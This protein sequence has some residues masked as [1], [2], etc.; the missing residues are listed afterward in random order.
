MFCESSS[1]STLE[2]LVIAPICKREDR[3]DRKVLI[4]GHQKP[5]NYVC[6]KILP[7]NINQ[8]HLEIS[9]L[10]YDTGDVTVNAYEQYL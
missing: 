8:W 7:Q 9:P 10:Q 3:F 2:A 4:F 5:F 6:F 1:K